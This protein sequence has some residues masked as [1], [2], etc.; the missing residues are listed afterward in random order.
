MNSPRI[1]L[2]IVGAFALATSP[3]LRAVDPATELIT[4][5]K[6]AYAAGNLD[7]AKAKFES[8]RQLDPK[9]VTALAYIRKIQ[10]QQAEHGAGVEQALSRIIVPSVQFKE[11][12]L[13]A[14]LDAMRQQAAKLSDGRQN[15][16]FVLQVPEAQAKAPITLNLRN[17]PFTEL[18]KY[19]GDMAGVNF[20]YDKYAIVVQP[21]GTA[22]AD[23]APANN[24][25]Q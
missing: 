2:V 25:P 13:T 1:I 23:P 4:E 5:A 3:A 15:L 22:K 17:I 21:A 19:V 12:E 6:A 20:V 7:A 10:T 24:T 16:N 14:V 18:M 11:A 9:N 8:A